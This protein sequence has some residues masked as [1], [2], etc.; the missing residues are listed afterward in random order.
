MSQAADMQGATDGQKG[1]LPLLT[2][3]H[4]GGIKHYTN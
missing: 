4:V 3:W 2:L 1:L